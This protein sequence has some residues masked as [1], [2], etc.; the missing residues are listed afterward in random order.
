MNKRK[1]KKFTKEQKQWAIEQYVSGALS[2]EEIATQLDTEAQAIYRWKVLHDEKKKGIR[3]T[4]IAEN[5]SPVETQKRVSE[6]EQEVEEYKKML[7][8]QVLMVELLKKLQNLPPSQRE[9]ELAGL[10]RTSKLL[11]LKRGPV[12]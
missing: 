8:E 11:A 2:A 3:L 1:R 4:E 12:K 9:N 5:L 7:A 10:I 6:L